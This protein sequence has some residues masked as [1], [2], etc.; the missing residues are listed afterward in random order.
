LR[1]A[2]D[3]VDLAPDDGEHVEQVLLG[4]HQL[5]ETAAVNRMTPLERAHQVLDQL[6]ALT[7]V[8]ALRIL[9]L[10]AAGRVWGH[11]IV[12]AATSVQSPERRRHSRHA[13]ALVTLVVL[14]WPAAASALVGYF[15]TE[16]R[17]E[18]VLESTFHLPDQAALTIARQDLLEANEIGDPARIREA[19][20]EVAAAKRGY[21]ADYASCVGR[22]QVRS[23]EYYRQF[24]CKLSL[25][26]DAGNLKTL[27]RTLHV[28]GK[29]T[30][31]LTTR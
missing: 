13:A 22:G 4:A 27:F 12:S 7:L 11:I 29:S 21:S 3:Q 24:R 16:G 1:A 17:A 2:D 15:W 19:L 23:H 31:V 25:S 18:A 14:A 26:S 30:Y 6:L 5:E 20:Q 10:P 8:H 28:T 9:P